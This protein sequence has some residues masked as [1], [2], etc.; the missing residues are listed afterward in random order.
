MRMKKGDVFAFAGLWDHWEDESES[1]NSRVII[2]TPS[3]KAM[4]PIHERMPAII[5]RAL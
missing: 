1:L 3:N 5:A 4:K 2:I